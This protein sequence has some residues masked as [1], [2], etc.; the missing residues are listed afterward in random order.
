MP[1]PPRAP[2][3]VKLPFLSTPGNGRE[4]TR[5]QYLSLMGWGIVSGAG[6]VVP[7]LAH[8]LRQAGEG[9]PAMAPPEP[10][11]SISLRIQEISHELAPGRSVKTVAYNGQVPGPLL[12]VREG[13]PV[14]VEVR[15][16]TK[17]DEL[18][19]WHG[20]HVAAEV[21]GAHEEGTPH[22]PAGGERRYVFTP[23]P[24]GTRWY[25]SHSR[26]GNNLRGG[27]YSGQF[28]MMIV[29]PSHDPGQYDLEVPILLHEWEG[30]FSRQGPRDVEYRHYSINGRSLGAGEPVRV[31]QGQRALLRIVNASATMA[32]RLALTGHRFQVLALD[33]NPIVR[34]RLVPVLELGPGER[35]DAIVEMNNP[36]VWVLGEVLDQQRNAGL[37]LVFEYAGQSG[38]PRWLAAVPQR[39]DYLA[40]SDAAA[41]EPPAIESD[42]LLPLVIRQPGNSHHWTIN[43]K[44]FPD[45]PPLMVE[46]DRRYR[47]V[48][49]NQ[50]ADPHPMHL[51]RHSFWI[52]RFDGQAASGLLKDV[53]VV[54]AWKQ[55][56]VDF[57]ANFPGPTLL[58]C[59][60]QFH[61]DEGLLILLQYR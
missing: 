16:E 25:H 59:H 38:A 53:V 48:F 22:V 14:A 44:S 29:E 39:W 34:P 8:G 31:R 21:D 50:S 23:T 41:A 18:V 33:G 36:G 51:H 35:V 60:Q 40:F 37:G 54:P 13:R 11:Q 47:L 26:T 57:I 5:R 7:P 24:A 20:L 61:M 56:E 9:A 43:G 6:W 15:N 42:A 4:L 49:D 45:T 28:G 12:R 17:S 19:H 27:T 10:Q 46:T 3:E 55:V 32:H 30:R 52:T 58:H 1:D 2:V